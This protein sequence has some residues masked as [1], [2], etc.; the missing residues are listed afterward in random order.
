ML[1][2]ISKPS[3]HDCHNHMKLPNFYATDSLE[4]VNT[5]QKFSFSKRRYGPFGF[6]PRIFRQYLTKNEIE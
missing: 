5:T 6:T 2:Y 3:L 4:Y 1:L